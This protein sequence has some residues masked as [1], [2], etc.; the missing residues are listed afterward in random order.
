MI[1]PK[2]FDDLS[3][4]LAGSLPS[5]FSLLQDDLKRNLH[6]ALEAS[7]SHLDLV[8]RE[9]FDIQQAVLARTREKLAVLEKQVAEL[10][11]RL[12]QKD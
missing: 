9:E 10:E 12:T 4:R 7:L 1:D 6:S 3:Q 11:A 5:G 8:T 2:V